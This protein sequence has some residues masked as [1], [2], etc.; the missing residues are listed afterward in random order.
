MPF[1]EARP[2]CT[3]E[4]VH[5]ECDAT[6]CAAANV[7]S[8]S[9][10]R[11]S[12]SKNEPQTDTGLGESDPLTACSD[13]RDRR[14]SA[15]TRVHTRALDRS[16]EGKRRHDREHIR[17]SRVPLSEYCIDVGCTAQHVRGERQERHPR[18]KARRKARKGPLTDMTQPET[19]S[20]RRTC[21]LTVTT[22]WTPLALP[23]RT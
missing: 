1:G 13:T 6:K 2:R 18:R 5:A 8:T 20:R 12:R 19:I 10:K 4:S 11:A 16:R 15:E 14:S 22:P 17:A 21:R 7:C 3:C 23:N 9:P